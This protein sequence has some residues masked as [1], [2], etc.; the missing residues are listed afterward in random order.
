MIPVSATQIAAARTAV[1]PADRSVAGIGVVRVSAVAEGGLGAAGPVSVTAASASTTPWPT[2]GSHPPAG[3][4][5]VSSMRC[6]TWRAVS[7]GERA[8]TSAAIAL[9]TGA[10]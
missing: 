10:A 3:R 9:T 4:R 1:T 6:T 5:A 2:A 8:R 7:S